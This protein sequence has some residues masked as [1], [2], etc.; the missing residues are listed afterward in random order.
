M[1]KFP[2]KLTVL[3]SVC[4]IT[5]FFAGITCAMAVAGKINL[6][7]VPVV[8][9]VIDRISAATN[10]GTGTTVVQNAVASSVTP[11]DQYTSITD[12]AV[13]DS[14]VY[15]A[16][17][18][19]EKV[20]KLNAAG[21]VV[22]TYTADVQVNGVCVNDNVVYA[23]VGAANGK[24]IVL[25]SAMEA[26]ATITV[27][28]T[29]S[30]I[31]VQGTKAYVANRFDNEISVIDLSAN[32][33]IKTIAVNGR[34]AIDMAAANGKLY[35][36]CHLPEN[37]ATEAVVSAN[38]VVVD[39]ASDTVT[40][41]IELV[42]GAGGVKGITA[43]PDGKAVYVSHV[44]ARY[45][46]PT[47]QLDRGWIN[48]N[49][50]S[51]IDTTANTA[52]AVMLDEVELGAANPWGIAVSEDGKQLIVAL[53]GTD[54]AMIV[55][56]EKMNAKIAAVKAG[57]GVVAS[58][59]RIVDYLPFL[60]DCR[61]RVSLNGKGARA[62]TI[63]GNQAYIGQYFTG[64]IAVIDLDGKQ[65]MGT[66]NFVNQPENDE[67]RT[68]EILFGD[69]NLC[70]QKWQSCLSCHPDAL[71]DGLNW[72]NLNDGLG[73]PKSA[74]SLLYSHRTP[75]VMVTGIR[76]T[77]EIA[78]RAGMK[79]IQFNV[80]DE[81]QLDTIDQYLMSLRPEQSP[82]LNTD[83]TLTESAQRGK[84]LFE[85]AGCVTCHPAPLY[86]DMKTHDVGTTA[87]DNG[88]WESR[89]MDTPTLVEVWRTGAWLHDGRYNNMEDVVRYFAPELTDQEVADLANFVLSIGDEGE[90][91]GVEQVFVTADGNTTLCALVPGGTVA[92]FTVR[93]QQETAEGT[94]V[95]KA[96]L[97]DGANGVI[98]S[99]ETT[100]SD[101]ACNTAGAIA[102]G[103][104]FAIPTEN[105]AGTTLTITIQN[106]AGEDLATPYVLQY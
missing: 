2:K 70:Y 101:L 76:D 8:G 19:G 20:Y 56:I 61:V 84:A 30:A 79:F 16:D 81:E 75:P 48:T 15:A 31:V 22:A 36:A 41:T 37:A 32:T 62:L 64:N 24:V 89:V 78:V 67:V 29:P 99:Y 9:T 38:V 26:T 57:N 87:N 17:K 35:V 83:G 25:N 58:A 10:G 74:K 49:G 39:M 104:G 44:I 1:K 42:N 53:S 65:Q 54:E 92:G 27:G 45:T 55:D 77:A 18:T 3:L 52:L 69:A 68:G 46:Y 71:A 103:S 105:A 96:V 90:Q 102:L 21:T 33:V 5:V 13:A 47:T 11:S 14:F 100:V 66:M 88:N 4:L 7:G 23:L 34:E 80:M 60:D 85:S 86:T 6:S 106:A 59:D 73:N 91:Y 95:I 63:S 28:H 72:D 50:F 12:V 93:C 94:A 97:T 40:K 43:S 98:K 82:Y 51:I